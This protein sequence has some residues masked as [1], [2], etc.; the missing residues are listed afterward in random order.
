MTAQFEEQLSLICEL[1]KIDLDLHNL[2]KR[3]D[4]FSDEIREEAAT[5]NTAKN[6]LGAA[7]AELAEV[8]KA[9][10]T[11]EMEL[12]ASVENLR[13][14]EARLYAIKTNKEY[15]AAIKEVSEGKRINK[16][17]EDRILQ[18][19][20]KAEALTQKIT[21]LKKEYAD[22]EVVYNM[23]LAALKEDEKNIH[24]AMEEDVARRP[25]VLAKIEKVI[26]NK[27]EFVKQRYA[28]A[29][30]C[31]SSGVC[32]GC[33][34]RVPPQLFNEMLRRETFKTCPNCQRLIYVEATP[35][36]ETATKD[37]ET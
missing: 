36:V 13:N 11:D 31:V 2:Q 34:T 25:L 5:Y 21:Q 22:K 28:V 29:V 20:E 26:L 33:S 35:A 24:K 17:R 19:M 18:A 37:I 14:R 6:L 10:R 9:K 23:K 30:A 4:S 8:E 32:Q 1:Q 16:E 12:A 3:L 27:Y 7:E 15:Q